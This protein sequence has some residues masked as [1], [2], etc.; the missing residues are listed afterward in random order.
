MY[1]AGQIIGVVALTLAVISF[2]QKTH[3]YILTFQLLANIM[4]V[5]HFGLIGAYTGA[6]LNFV[7]M[8][9]SVVFVNKGKSWADNKFWLWLF[10]AL[11]VIAGVV[12]WESWKSVLPIAGMVCSTVAFWIKT[13]RY[14]RLVSFPSSPLWL[15][16][17]MLGK[18]YA[19][20][21]TEVINMT[22]IIIAIIR[23][24]LKEY[25]MNNIHEK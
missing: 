4:F 12:T 5:L 16:Y 22:S 8:L 21:L 1:L 17:N 13:P 9:R 18:S 15:V 24:D 25:K 3:K 6:L 11:S 7:A 14:V 19:G 2:Q 10:C 20:V 23:L